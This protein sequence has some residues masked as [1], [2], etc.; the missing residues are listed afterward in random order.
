MEHVDGAGAV[1]NGD[2]AHGCAVGGAD[3]GE[4]G[5]GASDEVAGKKGEEKE[6]GGE[7]DEF[8]GIAID[9]VARNGTC[10]QGGE[11]VT[12][13]HKA[14]GVFVG[15]VVFAEIKWQQGGDDH[16][17]EEYHEVGR[18]H[19]RIVGVPKSFFHFFSNSPLARW[20]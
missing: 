16:E 15:V 10:E 11:G 9:E 7:E 17:G 2:S 12:R 19:L 18:P 20:L 14:D 13:K 5:H 3:D 4:E 8:S 6:V 1:G